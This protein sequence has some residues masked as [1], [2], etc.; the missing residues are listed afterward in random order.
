MEAVF[1]GK[2]VASKVR[3][4]EAL[5]DCGSTTR[6]TAVAPPGKTGKSV[7]VSLTTLE[8]ELTGYGK[9]KEPF[10]FKYTHALKQLLS[11]QHLGRGY[12]RV[13]SSPRGLNC[14]HT[15]SH[16]FAYKSAVTLTATPAD[17]SRFVGWGGACSGTGKCTVRMNGAKVAKANFVLK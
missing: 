3:N 13:T 4:A 12:G 10:L 7:R 5:L 15:C 17:D 6:I 16:R 14:A 11:V 8:S 2:A 9:S 1:F